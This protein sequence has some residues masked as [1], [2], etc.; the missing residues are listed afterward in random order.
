VRPHLRAASRKSDLSRW[1]SSSENSGWGLGR[2]V[3]Q[4]KGV[5][6]CVEGARGPSARRTAQ[7]P[8][9]PTWSACGR[10]TPNPSK[11][12]SPPAMVPG[13]RM[14]GWPRAAAAARSLAARRVR[15]AREAGAAARP[16]PQQGLLC[17][18]RCVL[19]LAEQWAATAGR[20]AFHVGAPL[21]RPTPAQA[22]WQQPSTHCKS[23]PSHFKEDKS[24][25]GAART[26]G[27]D[28]QTG[29][30]YDMIQ[31][32]EVLVAEGLG[33]WGGQARCCRW[34]C[35][36]H[37][38]QCAQAAEGGPEGCNA[39]FDTH[40]HTH[41]HTHTRTHTR[42]RTRTIRHERTNARARA[43]VRTHARA[44]ASMWS[45]RRLG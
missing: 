1:K 3:G 32:R 12:S 21:Q 44:H 31:A 36:A 7:P 5:V 8:A 38:A 27:P 19:A 45:H 39:L 43:R 23:T 25:I 4:V 42:T 14:D 9:R 35:V 11:N 40:A 24:A 18:R 16:R 26:A 17:R 13:P 30:S 33:R 6:G 28:E 15:A 29:P 10:P 20:A 41:A 34:N 2:G 37:G 22:R